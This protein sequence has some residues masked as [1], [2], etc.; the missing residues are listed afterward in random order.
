[1]FDVTSGSPSVQDQSVTSFFAGFHF[2]NCE[3]DFPLRPLQSIWNTFL[4]KD[5]VQHQLNDL[6]L[7]RTLQKKRS[8]GFDCEN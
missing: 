3:I 5:S 6:L 4:L 1:M 2:N 7:L 8:R